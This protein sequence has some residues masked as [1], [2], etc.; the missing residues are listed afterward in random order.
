VCCTRALCGRRACGTL[1]EVYPATARVAT[2]AFPLPADAEPMIE[3][4]SPISPTGRE[5]PP[6]R[7]FSGVQISAALILLLALALRVGYVLRTSSFTPILDGHSYD[8]LAR[9]LANGHGWAYGNGAYRPPG[10]P[11]YL[12]AIYKVVGV[13]HLVTPGIGIAHGQYG[14]PRLVQA[15]VSTIAVG[16][17][18]LV[19]REVTGVKVALAA[20]A[21]AAVYPALILVGVSM[22]TE[23]LL[24]PLILGATLCALRARRSAHPYRWIA[25]AGVLAGLSAL[26]RGNGIVIAPALAIVV[27]T[28]RPRLRWRSLAAPALLLAIAALTISP[29]TVRNAVAQHAFI[30][31]TDELGATLAGTYNSVAARHHFI[32]EAGHR[33]P[34]YR[35]I[36]NDQKL[37]ESVRASRLLSAV[38][39]YVGKH[40]ADVPKAMFWN[41]V[42]LADLQGLNISHMTART[43]TGATASADD[44]SVYVFWVVGLLAI[45]GLFTVDARRIPKALWLVPFFIWLSEAPIT[46]GTPRFRAALDP[47]IILLAACAVTAAA[48]A[49]ASS[50]AGSRSRPRPLQRQAAAG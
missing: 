11:F 16:L 24:V 5:T 9:S 48:R 39:T 6:S 43:D 30:P 14:P 3:T 13:P 46:T 28:A 15:V 1:A 8:V 36:R 22:M 26:T 17:L 25:G 20:M 41:T 7:R 37:Q 40:P 23:S 19:A 32:W 50:R 35:A 29:W 45:A 34:Q 4:E 18:G 47:W 2:V 10:Y 31:V 21:I 12:A 42:R 38:L 49:L 27:W 44:A 33:Y